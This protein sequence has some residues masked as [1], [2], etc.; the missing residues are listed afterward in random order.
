MLILAHSSGLHT[1]EVIMT[2]DYYK[3]NIHSLKQNKTTTGCISVGKALVPA[4]HPKT[5][6]LE[7]LIPVVQNTGCSSLTPQREAESDEKI[8]LSRQGRPS[9]QKYV[10]HTEMPDVG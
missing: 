8:I 2:T 6:L 5:N 3:L 7:C 4:Q 10:Q 9:C 1:S